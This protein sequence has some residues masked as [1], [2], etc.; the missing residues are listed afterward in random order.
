M[1]P[2]KKTGGGMYLFDTDAITNIL[3]KKPSE[4]MLK[5]IRPVTKGQSYISTITVGEIIYGAFK[6]STPA[7]HIKNLKEVLLPMVYVMAF[8]S[9]AAYFYGKIRAGLEADGIIISHADM[10]IASIAFAYD[11]TVITG[12]A[13]HFTRI[14]DLKVENWI[15]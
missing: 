4:K 14:Q 5:K 8:D 11:L 13:R 1:I 10:Q 7:R 15:V 12:N 9:R 6:S 3:K 2:G